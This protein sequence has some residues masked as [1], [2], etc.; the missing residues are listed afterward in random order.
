MV[1]ETQIEGG[2]T[3]LRLYRWDRESPRYVSVIIHGYGEHAGR[4]GH[5]AAALGNRGAVV[6]AA[7]Y[8]GHGK[9]E[10]E[11]ALVDD[12]DAFVIDTEHVVAHARE[13]HPELPLV[14]IGHSLGGVVATR[15]AQQHGDELAALVLSGPVIGG[16][17]DILGLVELAEIPD[18]PIDPSMLSRDPEVGRAYAEDPLVYHGPFK[19]ATLEGL[20]AA[21]DRVADGGSLGDLP[22][23]W[24]HGEAD[25]LAPLAQ[26]REAIAR[27]RGSELQEKVY[28]SARHEIF[29][30][31]NKEEV[32][33]DVTGF[34]DRALV[35]TGTSANAR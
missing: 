21:V 33:A 17:P 2:R 12:I 24:I 8:P 4:Y 3:A 1:K 31:T 13:R 11:R 5:V 18:I 29:N 28:A 26:A 35:T 23:L 15:Y 10:G 32:L 34:I 7:D 19:R 25:P 27:V 14:L 6:Y 22:T 20:V 16:N 9:S 30:E